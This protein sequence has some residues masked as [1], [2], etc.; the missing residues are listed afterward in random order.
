[1]QNRPE[2]VYTTPAAVRRQLSVAIATNSDPAAQSAEYGEF[3]T[4]VEEYARQVSNAITNTYTD[5]TF[6]PYEATYNERV[7]DAA[8]SERLRY[9]RHY[10][11]YVYRLPDD[12]LSVTSVTIAGTVLTSD[13][14]QLSPSSAAVYDALRM[15]DVTLSSTDPFTDVISIE[16]TWG[17]HDNTYKRYTDTGTTIDANIT[18]TT[19]TTVSVADASSLEVYEYILINS[20][21]M[22]I[23]AIDTDTNDLTVERGVNGFT[24]STHTSGDTVRRFNVVAD[25]RMAASRLVAYLWQHRNDLGD[26][27]QITDANVVVSTNIPRIV[28][29]I[30]NRYAR[31]N[32]GAI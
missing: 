23:T 9:D 28:Q 11:E 25:L 31:W 1:M 6:V 22:W 14:Y 26:T 12:C 17:Y 4:F 13:Q 15:D 24:A 8:K 30:L 3:L 20:E 32:V 27:V 19:T 7:R 29:R 21:L 10:G 5:R 16:G 18:D 2:S